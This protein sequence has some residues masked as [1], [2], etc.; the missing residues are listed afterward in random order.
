MTECNR[1][2]MPFSSLGAKVL[3]AGF[4]S[5]RTARSMRLAAEA[6]SSNANRFARMM[7]SGQDSSQFV[8]WRGALDH[9]FST[10]M[11]ISPATEVATAREGS[12]AHSQVGDLIPPPRFGWRQSA[13][14]IGPGF[15]AA[16]SAIWA[17]GWLFWSCGHGPVRRHVPV[18]RHVDSEEQR[19]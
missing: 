15:L 17:G 4:N 2:R 14:L 1:C 12:I 8:D 18:A 3:V 7:R 9:E 16:G 5:D 19:P 6:R 13:V 11:S 10:T